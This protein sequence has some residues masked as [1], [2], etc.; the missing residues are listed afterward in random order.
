M[1]QTTNGIF[2]GTTA[3]GGANNVSGGGFGTVFSITT[4][5]VLTSLYS[6]TGGTD[7]SFP[8]AGLAVGPDGGLYGTTTGGGNTALNAGLGFGAV[9]DIST[10]GSMIT[11]AAFDGTNGVSPQGTL[12]LG[13]DDNFYGTTL[14]GGAIF[15]TGYGTVFRVTINGGLDSLLSFDGVSSGAYPNAGLAQVQSGHFLRDDHGRGNQ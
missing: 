5:G 4:N 9:F 12:A 14:H 7:G 8:Q 1:V 10:N 13:S 15:P 3:A 2:Y 11:L 6:F